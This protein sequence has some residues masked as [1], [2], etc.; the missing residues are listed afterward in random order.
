MV[1]IKL[2]YLL[3][4]AIIAP[5]KAIT[6]VRQELLGAVISVR[7]RKYVERECRYKSGKIVQVIDSEIIRAMI[8]RESYG[9]N[10]FT[11][12]KIGEIEEG[13]PRIGIG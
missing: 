7:L 6:I 13:S 12:T 11:S 3:A 2:H 8:Q 1:H 5:V 9:F 10:T 4:K